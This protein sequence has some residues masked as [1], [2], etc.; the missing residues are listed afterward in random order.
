MN[1]LPVSP[2][3]GG[4]D[5]LLV[6]LHENTFNRW[7][8]QLQSGFFFLGNREHYLY[9]SEGK[10]DITIPAGINTISLTSTPDLLTAAKNGPIILTGE[11]G[12]YVR[13]TN[14][15]TVYASIVPSGSA[16]ATLLSCSVPGELVMLTSSAGV[17]MSSVPSSGYLV[18]RNYYYFDSTNR[19]VYVS[20]NTSDT[21]RIETLYAT[22]LGDAPKLL[23]EEILI[24]NQGVLRTTLSDVLFGASGTALDPSITVIGTGTIAASAVVGNILYPEQALAED[25][26]ACV[27]YYINHSYI[28]GL[29]GNNLSIQTLSHVA[30]HGTL[31]WENAFVYSYFDAGTFPSSGSC[32]VQLNPALSGIDS[33][34]LYIAE[35]IHPAEHLDRLRIFSSPLKLSNKTREQ[36]RIT[37][38]ALDKDDNPLPKIPVTCWITKD[39]ATYNTLSMDLEYPLGG[40]DFRGEAHFA[41]MA[42]PNM[43]GTYTICASSLSSTGSV[44]QTTSILEVCDPMALTDAV[45]AGKVF[46]YLNNRPDAL[47]YYDLYVYLTNQAGIPLLTDQDVLVWC[48]NGKLLPTTTLGVSGTVTASKSLSLDFGESDNLAGLRVAVC[49]YIPA[50]LQDKIYAVPEGNNVVYK[51]TSTPLEVRL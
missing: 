31:F 5:D 28:A 11:W 3:V 4:T 19:I 50:T 21:N 20:R 33:G 8:P 9:A 47:G 18:D 35:P 30:D 32:Y 37:V 25:T 27:R 51:F 22:Y 29:S 43:F 15:L 38:L 1:T 12:D 41:F 14:C 42:S 36:A 45:D 39:G 26:V 10:E 48:D 24:V 23:Q 6:K 46:L 2:G 49:K 17:T 7:F 13:S 44:V 34:F 40:T 16:T